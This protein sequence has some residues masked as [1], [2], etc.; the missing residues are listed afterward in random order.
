[1]ENTILCTKCDTICQIDGEFPKF[2]AWCDVC[3]DYATC[4]IDG[5]TADYLAT[6]IDE[7]REQNKYKED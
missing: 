1:M 3:N 4:D 7:A 2:F 5:Y 6:K